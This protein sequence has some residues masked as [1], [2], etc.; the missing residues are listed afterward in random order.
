[1]V[2]AV[3]VAV[4]AAAQGGD[5]QRAARVARAKVKWRTC[6]DWGGHIPGGNNAAA[7]NVAK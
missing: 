7:D 1:M 2:M 4:I 3:A 5:N 6:A